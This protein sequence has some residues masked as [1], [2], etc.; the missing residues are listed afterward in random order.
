RRQPRLRKRSASRQQIPEC[1]VS[2]ETPANQ[3][4]ARCRG[5]V[6]EMSAADGSDRCSVART[7]DIC[8]DFRL[9]SGR[10][11]AGPLD[12][13]EPFITRDQ[14]VCRIDEPAAPAW[15]DHPVRARTPPPPP[16]TPAPLL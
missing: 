1:C 6:H 12:N 5:Q 11:A 8:L 9:V 13:P 15:R 2:I 10:S 7:S 16:L 3:R 14:K 4:V